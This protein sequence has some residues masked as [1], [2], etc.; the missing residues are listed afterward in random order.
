MS[1]TLAVSELTARL[2]TRLIKWS[3]EEVIPK[4]QEEHRD[5][6]EQLWKDSTENRSFSV[7]CI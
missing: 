5:E 2:L 3:S 6:A 1:R 7:P 4:L